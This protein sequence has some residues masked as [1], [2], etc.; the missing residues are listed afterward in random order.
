MITQEITQNEN[1]L[2]LKISLVESDEQ[3]E[4]IIGSNK[5]LTLIQEIKGWFRSKNHSYLLLL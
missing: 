4:I 3:E 2:F 5:K 1:N